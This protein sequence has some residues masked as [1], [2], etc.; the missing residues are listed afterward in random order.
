VQVGIH[1]ITVVDDR[2][3]GGAF[4]ACYRVCSHSGWETQAAIGAAAGLP[5]P[6]GIP[7]DWLRA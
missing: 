6:A 1:A 7:A 4:A 2:A 3:A 5:S